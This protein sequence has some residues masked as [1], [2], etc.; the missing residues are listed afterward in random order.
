LGLAYSAIVLLP[1]AVL[2]IFHEYLRVLIIPIL[3]ITAIVVWLAR[4]HFKKT[5]RRGDRL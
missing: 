1:A 4:R 5:G 3:V 2:L